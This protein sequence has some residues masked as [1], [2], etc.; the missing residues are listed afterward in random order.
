[1]TIDTTSRAVTIDDPSSISELAAAL[2]KAQAAMEGAKKDSTNLHFKASYAD[3]ASVW[4][5]IRGPLTSNGLAIMQWPRVVEGGVE[6]HTVL[7]H[8]SGQSIRDTLWMPCAQMTPHGVG[9]AITYARR[10]ALMSLAGVA[11]VDDDGNDAS[12]GGETNAASPPARGSSASGRRMAAD[13]PHLLD[14]L[15]IKGTLSNAPKKATPD[16]ARAEKTKTWVDNA[17][18]TLNLSQQGSD[19]LKTFWSTNETQITWVEA[20]FPQQ[21]ER[22]NTAYQNALEAAV[23]KEGPKP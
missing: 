23:S 16:Q 9:S 19:S 1:M 2:V 3:L 4:D 17:I 15:R 11:P 13:E 7:I 20:N 6:V 5:A 12:K 21:Y 22:L 8:S 18:S 10:Y 14:E